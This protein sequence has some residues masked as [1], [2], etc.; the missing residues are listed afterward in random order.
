MPRP[1]ASPALRVLRT[2]R[3]GSR[4]TLRRHKD[5]LALAALCRKSPAT[6][7]YSPSGHSA[8]P[9]LA[10]DETKLYPALVQS[11]LN[12]IDDDSIRLTKIS[13]NTVLG[14]G[15]FDKG[16]I[17][18]L[19]GPRQQLLFLQRNADNTIHLFKPQFDLDRQLY[20]VEETVYSPNGQLTQAPQIIEASAALKA[21]MG[22]KYPQAIWA[23]N[24]AAPKTGLRLRITAEGQAV[25]IQPPKVGYQRFCDLPIGTHE[26]T[27][28]NEQTQQWQL[29]VYESKPFGPSTLTVSQLNG[30][31][32]WEVAQQYLVDQQGQTTAVGQP[33]QV[34]PKALHAAQ[35]ANFGEMRLTAG[36][37]STLFIADEGSC[38]NDDLTYFDLS[39][40]GH[41]T[42]FW[43]DG[44]PVYLS[45]Q[46][47]NG[48][49]R[50]IVKEPVAL[51]ESKTPAE[52]QL[53]TTVYPVDYDAPET[54]YTVLTQR[55]TQTLEVDAGA[56]ADG[57]A[58]HRATPYYSRIGKAQELS[59]INSEGH[60]LELSINARPNQVCRAA[61]DALRP[62]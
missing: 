35:F 26:F 20:Q 27:L 7:D 55:A 42:V 45:Y 13:D 49:L 14:W 48:S 58:A 47:D 56:L 34:E 30:N 23:A 5:F 54:K 36:D 57:Y 33:A 1:S 29:L 17:F 19:I 10:A 61:P 60:G 12:F 8:L 52:L 37:D 53:K 51:D 21:K 31:F 16:P 4:M 3:T 39:T 6:A 59:N 43:K 62:S 24:P 38:L 50:L 11:Q 18:K 46:D 22:L 32:R 44:K 41:N 40:L 15:R 25:F 9:W 2:L 28:F